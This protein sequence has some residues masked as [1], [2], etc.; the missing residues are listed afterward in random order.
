MSTFTDDKIKSMER[1]NHAIQA[2]ESIT[3]YIKLLEQDSNAKMPLEDQMWLY[4]K[5]KEIFDLYYI[6]E[7]LSIAVVSEDDNKFLSNYVERMQTVMSKMFAHILV[8]EFK[9]YLLTKKLSEA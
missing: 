9:L 7:K 6:E 8:S 3:K 5:G 4:E 1:F 2:E